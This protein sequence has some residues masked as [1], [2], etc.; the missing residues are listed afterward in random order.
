MTWKVFID[1]EAGTTGLQIRER[2][3]GRDEITLLSLPNVRRKDPVA[4]KDMLNVADV[5]IL[6]LPDAAASEAAA[7]ID[8]TRT[9]VIDASSAHRVAA[10]G[11]TYGFP[12]MASGQRE[13]IASASRVSNPGC[14]P[15]G[16][17]ALMRPLVGA[18]LVPADWPVNVNAVSG[19]SGGGRAMVDEFE[20]PG[21]AAPAWRG[22][23]LNL[24]HKHVP[25]M[26]AYAGLR[27]PPLFCPAVGRFY[28]GMAVEIPLPLW[29]LPGSP[30]L[31]DLRSALAAAYAGEFFV[32]LGEGGGDSVDPQSLN[33]TNRLRLSVFGSDV[34]GQARLIAVLDNL[35][36]GAAGAAVQNLNLMLGLAENAGLT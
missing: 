9:R 10:D 26:Q 4:R 29:A 14:Y 25:E 17:I 8:Q 19:Y 13:A 22:Y 18:G 34:R 16:F 6:C 7:L 33:G 12:E 11:W 23:A 28:N 24:A 2:L 32:D 31:A 27:H 5:A 1:G 20:A 15:T 35:G 30:R 36:K 21:S 3:D